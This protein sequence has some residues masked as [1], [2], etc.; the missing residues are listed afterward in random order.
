[1]AGRSGRGPAQTFHVHVEIRAPIAYVF[2]WCTDYRADDARREKDRYVR[3]ILARAPRRVV[4][5]DLGDHEGGGWWWSRYAVDL[6]PPAAWHAES[7]GAYRTLTL[8]Y[9]LTALGPERTRFDLT[10]RRWPTAL[11]PRRV[12]R[13]AME[14]ETTR[15]WKNFAAA[16]EADYRRERPARRRGRRATPGS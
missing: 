4:Y 3:R 7:V 12:G 8:D 2:R 5:E 6:R 11:G 14:R 1:M 15:A 10:W 9:A 16:L 13:A